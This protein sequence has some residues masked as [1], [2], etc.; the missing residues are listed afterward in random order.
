MSAERLNFQF[1]QKKEDSF[2]KVIGV[3]GGG[4]NAVNHMFRLGIH[5]VGFIVCNTDSQ[6]L[7]TSPVPVKIQLGSALTEGRGAGNKPEIGKQ[8]ALEN[9][10]DVKNVLQPATRMVFI[11]AGMGGGTGTGGAPVIAGLCREQGYLTV[12]IVTIPFRN[13]G[14]RRIHQAVE[15]IREME[16][17]VDCLLIIN[18]ERI[19][20]MYGDFPISQAFAKADDVLAIAAKGIAEI[21]T[22]PGYINVDFADVETVM[23]QSGVAIMGT[24]MAEGE[25]RAIAAAEKAFISPLLNNNDIK[26]AKNI[27][28]N[29]TSGLEEITMDEIGQI[30][31]YVQRKA[32]FDADLI[33][34]NG[35][36]ET[37]GKQISVTIIATGFSTSSIPE[38]LSG[39]KP[40]K[41]THLLEEKPAAGPVKRTA[42]TTG[43]KEK[44]KPEEG[45][46]R[47]MEFPIPPRESQKS[48]YDALYEKTQK[49]EENITTEQVLKVDFSRM[50]EDDLED[51]ENVPAYVRK[52]M[53]ARKQK[54]LNPED[55]SNYTVNAD[56]KKKITIR[57]NNP[58]IHRN[59]D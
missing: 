59:I 5:N 29:I 3:G 17:H 14:K 31:D 57:E 30:T 21:I 39:Q 13:E 45:K 43:E 54:R 38:L 11:T 22:V 16:Q 46:Q 42:F 1:E 37:L 24:G 9:R 52:Q 34:G 58:Y 18:N 25:G 50:P 36:D 4:G 55:Y 15:G 44:Q 32:G 41:E 8:A 56:P 7:A 26:G 6:A 49:P 28:L 35:V 27:L 33:W 20:E 47:T 2:I 23:R 51:F 10:E 48:E 40:L 19:R 53:L 12:G